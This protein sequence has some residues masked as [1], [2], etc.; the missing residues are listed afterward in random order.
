MLRVIRSKIPRRCAID[1]VAMMDAIVRSG[2]QRSIPLRTTSRGVSTP[3]NIITSTPG[4]AP[5]TG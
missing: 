5:A 4:I 2:R 3:V 1:V